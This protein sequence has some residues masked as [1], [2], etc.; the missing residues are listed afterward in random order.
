VFIFAKPRQRGQGF[1]FMAF[2]RM[3]SSVSSVSGGLL[4]NPTD[5]ATAALP[6]YGVPP[7][8]CLFGTRSDRP[9]PVERVEKKIRERSTRSKVWPNYP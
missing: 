4:G 7:F 9:G 3:S 2:S 6:T 8:L 1:N 5:T